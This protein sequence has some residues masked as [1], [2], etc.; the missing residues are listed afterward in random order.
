MPRL[1][2]AGFLA[3]D[4]GFLR[5]IFLYLIQILISLDIVFTLNLPTI[6]VACRLSAPFPERRVPIMPMFSSASQRG[7]LCEIC[8]QPCTAHTGE[9]KKM[10]KY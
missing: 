8:G 1:K 6:V 5:E 9:L 4:P 10:A 7:K 3:P 2:R